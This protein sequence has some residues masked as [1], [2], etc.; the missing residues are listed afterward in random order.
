MDRA[1]LE[2]KLRAF[3]T[4]APANVVAVYL[5]GGH[6]RDTANDRS[7]VDLAVLHAIEPPRSFESLPLDLESDLERVL[8]LP[9]QAVVLDHAPVDLVHR[10]LRD[11]ILVLDRDRSRRIRFEVKARNEFFDLR[12]VLERYRAPRA[13]GR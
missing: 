12:P 10:V 8:G 5:Y 6:A 2:A 3:F 1:T 7:D 11:G 13:A 4:D 9:V